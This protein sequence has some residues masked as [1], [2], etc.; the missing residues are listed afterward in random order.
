MG[1]GH[2][3]SYAEAFQELNFRAWLVP[4]SVVLSILA[5]RST[6]L[7]GWLP[8]SKYGLAFLLSLAASLVAYIVAK[9]QLKAPLKFIYSCFLKPLG[10]HGVNQQTRLESFYQDQAEVYDATRGGLLR[11]RK[12]M[13][14]LCAAQLKH[15]I[16]EGIAPEKLIWIDIGGGTGWNIERM[17]EYFSIEKFHRVY[18]VDLCPS[19]CKVARERFEKK[20]WK[21]V[22]VLCDDAASFHLPD[23]DA[24]DG[25]IGLVTLSYSLSMID[26]FFPVVDRIASLLHPQGVVG[27]ADFYVSGNAAS[28][29]EKMSGSQNRR[30]GWFNRFFWQIWFDFD[31]IN[32]AP[33]RRDYLEYKFGTLKSLNARNHFVIPGLVRI[34]YYVWIGCQR[35]RRVVNEIA[36]REESAALV[37]SAPALPPSSFHYQANSWRLPYDPSLPC[38]T[39]FRSYIYAFTWEDPRVDLEVLDLKPDDVMF[40]ITSAG[41]NALEYALKGR[42][43]RIHCVDINPCQGHLMELKLS[44]LKNLE[45][46]D[47]WKMFGDGK[48][49][50]FKALLDSQ[51]S[52][53]MSSHAYQFWSH[54]ASSF[55]SKFYLSGYSG[56][57]L[58]IVDTIVRVMGL[59]KDCDALCHAA[60]VEEQKRI[61]RTRIR[62]TLLAKWFVGMLSNPVFFWNAL[63][64]PVNQMNMFLSEGSA[65]QYIEDTLD[66]IIGRSLFRNDQYFYY[67][68]LQQKYSRQ[69][70]PSY[71]TEKGFHELKTSGA[72]D[73]FRL[74]T[75]SINN[76]LNNLAAESVTKAV[77]MDHMDWF[78]EPAA[79][80]EIASVARTIKP[81][82]A[83]YW[84]SAARYPW[85]NRIF[86]KNGFTVEP[87]GIREQGSDISLDRVNMYASFWRA[88]KA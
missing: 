37:A 20:G 9:D 25:N 71:L 62:P 49:P 34:P 33:G 43:K 6:L 68:C 42:P 55:R 61:W 5:L 27:V 85:Y 65:Q 14:R 7:E 66:P 31:H 36:D 52:P 24:P 60:T 29:A 67:L 77:L 23:L 50:G 87:M 64:V 63:G 38:H 22:V 44:G 13:L 45:Y 69:S 88:T 79:E 70:C 17:N 2:G 28:P 32:L 80:A 46:E 53:S 73:A 8:S 59:R 40:V 39:Q 15:Q 19:L 4:V 3:Q 56:L 83:V 74:H 10:N 57:A 58:R 76:V 51:L 30:V 41:D 1:L 84:R 75:D 35:E 78:D 12:T 81:G 54:N 18:L 16:E 11:G 26:T 48:H 21:N 72:L 47:F 82:G 86:E